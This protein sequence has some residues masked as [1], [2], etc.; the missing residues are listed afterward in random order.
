MY[1]GL[2]VKYPLFSTDSLGFS[3]QILEKFT[4]I[5]FHENPSI[6]TRVV[7]CERTDEQMDK[8]DEAN[9][10]FSQFCERALK[11]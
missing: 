8:R 4:K 1:I 5:N 9:S 10:R 7:L 6:G 11:V 2:R 3:R